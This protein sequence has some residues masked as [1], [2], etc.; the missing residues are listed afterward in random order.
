MLVTYSDLAAA[1]SFATV[2]LWK[3]G[4]T[5]SGRSRARNGPDTLVLP[6]RSTYRA[7]GACEICLRAR[8]K[9]PNPKRSPPVASCETVGASTGPGPRPALIWRMDL[10][11][12]DGK[13]AELAGGWD[14]EAPLSEESELPQ[15]PSAVESAT[16][17]SA[18][19]RRGRDTAAKGTEARGTHE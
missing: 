14:A 3:A 9:R 4:F 17:R 7:T 11:F 8:S 15:A 10:P 12:G 5:S 13:S 19:I 18:V 2:S 1:G 16:S 6:E